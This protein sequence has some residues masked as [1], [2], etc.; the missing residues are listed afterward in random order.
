MR[1]PR[2]TIGLKIA[3]DENLEVGARTT[4]DCTPESNVDGEVFA[5]T[6]HGTRGR[7]FMCTARVNRMDPHSIRVI[8]RRI[9]MS[10]R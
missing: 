5:Y 7:V 9:E 4:R 2:L 1:V 8:C 6:C 10:R 3:S